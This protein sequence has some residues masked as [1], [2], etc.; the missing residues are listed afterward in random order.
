MLTK[1]KC[2]RPKRALSIS[3]FTPAIHNNESL[4]MCQ[5]PKRA[6]SI[7]TVPSRKPHKLWLSSHVFA[8]I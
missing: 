7:S 3:T 1:P 2:Q 5:R 4:A 6:L 8:S